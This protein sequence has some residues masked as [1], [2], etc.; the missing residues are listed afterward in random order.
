M[1]PY[2]IAKHMEKIIL[3][4]VDEGKKSTGLIE[5]KAQTAQEYDKSMGVNSAGLKS[6]GVAVTLI[7][8]LARRDAA[9]ALYAK[10]VAEETLKAHYCR[11]EILK[12]QLNGYQS[13]NR[14]LAETTRKE[15]PNI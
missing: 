9:P 7:K 15:V 13:I 5:K 8:D 1:E 2:A 10:I 3:A 11:I 14:H 4:L 6:S 12:A